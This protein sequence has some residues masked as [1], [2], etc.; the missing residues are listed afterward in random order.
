MSSHAASSSTGGEKPAGKMAATRRLA[1]ILLMDVA[2]YSGLVSRDEAGTL[3]ALKRH[4]NEL[5]R[6]Q[7]TGHEGRVVKTTGDG[8]LAEFSS[9][10]QAVLCALKIQD[11]MARR[12]LDTSADRQVQFRIGIN[13][14]EVIF[15]DDDIFGDGVNIA[16]RLENLAEPN[17]ICLSDDVYRHVKGKVPADFQ[18]LGFRSLKGVNE[19]IRVFRAAMTGRSPEGP[20]QSQE[21]TRSQSPVPWVAVLPFDNLSGDPEQSYFSDGI[22]ND[23]IT[24]LS[25]FSEIAVIASHSMFT[26]KNKPTKIEKVAAD[27][28]VRYVVEGSVQRSA[29]T[30]RINVQ[31]IDAASETHL[32][33]ERYKRRLNGLFEIYDEIIDRL[34]SSLVARVEMSERE[35]ALRKPTENLEAYDHCLRGRELWYRWDKDSN[36]RA[37]SHFRQAINL[38]PGFAQPYRGLSYVLIQSCLSGWI[39]QPAAAIAE[40]RALAE[41]AVAL[42]PADFENY[43][44]L[45][46]ASLYCRDFGRSLASYE[47]AL[48]L[49]PNSADLLAEMADA[50]IHVGKTKEGIAKVVQAKELNRFYPDWYDW[51]IGIGAFHDG[52]YEDA[53]DALSRVGNSC[54]SLRCDLVATYVRL[55]RLDEA[56]ALVRAILEEQ[57][58]YRLATETLRPFKDPSVS[59]KFVADLR[60]A[61]LPD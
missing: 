22:T 27:L 57:P 40:A 39:D 14:G 5:V 31:L 49:N 13:L 21:I 58:A 46:F 18:Y 37:Q 12:N 38:D 17:G 10:V 8:L 25:K 59:R 6:P 56:R 48:E 16:A 9:A 44:Q 1:A 20:S 30:V 4:F 2:G 52:R 50:L 3:T 29:D 15:E 43:S 24:D 23:L 35:R 60:L 32:W 45:G 28:G 42:S 51:V 55:A 26:Y 11:E 33:S 34:V 19:R 47:K 53:L 36:E 41:K 7:I 61:G 54:T